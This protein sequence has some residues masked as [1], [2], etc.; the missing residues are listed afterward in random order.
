MQTPDNIVHGL[1]DIPSFSTIVLIAIQ[2][3]FVMSSTIVLPVI[4][5]R[6][7]DGNFAD[8]QRLVAFTMIA[9]GI[10][11][12]LQSLRSQYIGSGYLVPNLCGPNFLSVS[13]Q[14]AWLGGLPLMHGMILIAGLFEACFAKVIRYIRR[15]FPHEIT[16]LV[17]F[18]VG[19]SLMPIAVSKFMGVEYSG[20]E[21]NLTFVFIS[22]TTLF[23]MV[24]VNV[25]SSSSLKQY[26]VLIGMGVGYALSYFL[27]LLSS[28]VLQHVFGSPL[29][30]APGHWDTLFVFT[31]RQDLIVPFLIVSLVGALKTVGN[32]TMAQK[33]NDENWHEPDM[34]S[35]SKGLLADSVSVTLGGL[36]GGMA[37]DTSASNVGLSAATGVTSRIIGIVIGAV[38]F[39]F[40]FSPKLSA[41]FSIM[42]GPVMGAILLFV[43]SFMLLS[44]IQ[45]MIQT[46]PNLKMTF[47]LGLSLI[48]GL[49]VDILPTLYFKVPTYMIPIFNSSLTFS[50]IMAIGLNFIF[51]FKSIISFKSR[52]AIIA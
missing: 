7:I 29:V 15:L 20:D 33:I 22:A 42:P 34:N 46:K 40:G 4:V 17:V 43:V 36:L 9:A 27:G 21:I 1:D 49:S 37:T 19:I 23:V 5:I 24:C 30:A 38:Y 45:I 26:C 6:A 52:E 39:L 35:I 10:G 2:H 28:D 11:T 3:I 50:T 41:L 25:W 14:A 44:G 13:L 47:I 18:M 8:A 32:L 16:G 51:N 31:F 48:F 12:I